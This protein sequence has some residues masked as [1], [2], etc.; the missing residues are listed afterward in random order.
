MQILAGFLR[1]FDFIPMRPDT[2]VIAGGVPSGHRAYALAEPGKA[3]AIYLARDTRDQTAPA[4]RQT[5]TLQLAL[6]PGPYTVEWLN[7]RTGGVD[8]RED[9]RATNEVTS[10]NSPAFEEDVAVRIRGR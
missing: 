9:V 6:P 8:R 5:A 2:A 4:G 10:V 3:Y 7:P 1:G